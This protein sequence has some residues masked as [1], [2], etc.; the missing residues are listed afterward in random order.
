MLGTCTYDTKTTPNRDA[1]L[2]AAAALN[3]EGVIDVPIEHEAHGVVV[4]VHHAAHHVPLLPLRVPV[5]PL[6]VVDAD[7]P[8]KVARPP[9]AVRSQP[10]GPQPL[11]R[12]TLFGSSPSL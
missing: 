3:Q 10:T 5:W 6:H 9:G 2:E 1:W 12:Q 11:R 8:A 4:D 7:P